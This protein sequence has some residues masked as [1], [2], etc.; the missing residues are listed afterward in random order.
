METTKKYAMWAFWSLAYLFRPT[1]RELGACLL[2]GQRTR[3]P[4]FKFAP[5]VWHND[6]GFQWNIYFSGSSDYVE[7]RRVPIEVHV[8]MDTGAI[9]GFTVFDELL[10]SDARLK[11]DRWSTSIDELKRSSEARDGN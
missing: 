5:H 11:M 4:W 1:P 7:H 3:K 8:D 2:R 9:V 6:N 10:T